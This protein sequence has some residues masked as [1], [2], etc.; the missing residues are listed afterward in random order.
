VAGFALACF[1]VT[2]A[3]VVNA[4][5]EFTLLHPA[6][7]S[8]LIEDP[9]GAL[10][11][12]S[13]PAIF[14]GRI[15]SESRSIRRALLAFDVAGA[16]PAGSTVTGVTLWLDL[17][18]TSGGPVSIRL[19]RIVADWG[20]GPSSSSGGGGAPSATGDSTWI[21]RL[22]PDVFWLQAGGD[23]DPTPRADALVDQPG[24]YAWEAA[25]EM[26]ADVQ[27]WLDHPESAFGWMLLGDETQPQTV[28]RF[29]SREAS[30][31]T[32]RPLLEVDYVPPCS[33][34]P[35]G[36]GYWRNQCAA[37]SGNADA[38]GR[39]SSAAAG[40]DCRFADWILPCANR[41]LANLSL[42]RVDAC[43]S[44]LTSPPPSS[45]DRAAARL[46]VL[47]LN[48]C[49]GRLQTSCPAASTESECVST[50][51]G[52]LLNYVSGLIRAG[53]CR[54]AAACAATPD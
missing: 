2:A 7:D 42:P 13:G 19:H 53:D 27:S 30:D 41:V 44:L 48:V 54:R 32:N 40:A 6:K 28:K 51:I 43:G 11:N 8:T 36:P 24:L 9:S 4:S 29:D 52:D 33:P 20:E 25:P 37:L 23:F 1:L 14:S 47:V 16:V 10:A 26:V 35:A 38:A 3:G 15:N 45:C 39:E 5:A 18:S 22:Y 31:E 50:N 34:D 21:H 49:A 17:T 46:S 12:G